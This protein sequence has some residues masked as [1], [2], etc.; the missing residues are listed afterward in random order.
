EEDEIDYET[1]RYEPAGLPLIGGNSDVGVQVGAVGRLTRFYHGARPY[2]YRLDV[3]LTTSIRNN[4]GTIG[5]AQQED[6]AQ[7]DWP[8]ALPGVR[9]TPAVQF[10]NFVD[11]GYFGRGNASSA[12]VPAVVAGD[13][14]RFFQQRARELRVR[15]FMRFRLKKPVDLMFAQ[16]VR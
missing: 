15:N 10:L 14:K 7:L 11:A 12:E 16:I 13:P 1:P 2:L 5:L 3:L 9:T 6:I 8:N 4:A